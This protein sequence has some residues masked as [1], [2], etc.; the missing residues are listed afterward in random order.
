[1]QFN[2]ITNELFN[3]KGAFLKKMNCPIGMNWESLNNDAENYQNKYCQQCHKTVTD[4]SF[5]ND[6]KLT[7]L[8]NKNPKVCL[9]VSL[10]QS[11][12]IITMKKNINL[13]KFFLE[14]K[15]ALLKY[16]TE[17]KSN[18]KVI[19]TGRDIETINKAAIKGYYPLVKKIEQSEL[20]ASK[21]AVFQHKTTGKIFLSSDF[22]TH[23]TDT[24]F[25]QKVID[26]TFYYPYQFPSPYAAYLIPKDI[27]FGEHV[28][29]AD[30]IEDYI[31]SRWNQGDTYRL[32]SCEAVWNG[33]DFEIK[34]DP[35]INRK[36][37]V[38]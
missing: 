14:K 32:K 29:L 4:T 23:S 24:L 17:K 38:G 36:D 12:L 31:G 27:Q 21:Y 8:V 2:P 3:D 11:N 16:F 10:S 1:M 22:R 26:Y 25:Y 35:M 37:F 13:V 34:Y 30:L 9:K 19:H 5:L 6:K 33:I 15:N 7:L 28:L 20:I 18:L